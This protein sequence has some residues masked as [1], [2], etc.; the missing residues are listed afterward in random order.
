MILM[1]VLTFIAFILLILKLSPK[2]LK[3]MIGANFA[4]DLLLTAG[5]VVLFA[6]TGTF[7]GMMTGIIAGL[8]ISV[9]LLVAKHMFPHER[10][11]REGWKMKWVE[12]RPR[13]LK[14]RWKRK[15]KS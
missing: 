8:L 13:W 7:A 2:T 15:P 1:G 4:M 6:A 10:P 14:W 11:V 5:L 9:A 12:T 3:R